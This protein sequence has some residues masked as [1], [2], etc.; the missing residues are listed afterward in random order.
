MCADCLSVIYRMY[1]ERGGARVP[2]IEELPGLDIT[3][4]LRADDWRDEAATYG[5]LF[6]EKCENFCKGLF[7]ELREE[8][9]N[10]QFSEAGGALDALQFL[11]QIL[12]TAIWKYSVDPGDHLSDFARD[13]DRLDVRSEKLRLYEYLL[14]RGC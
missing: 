6:G 2:Y 13:F 10:K 8:I 9:A 7:D 4:A 11:Q 3:T 1:V 5:K 14:R 12:A